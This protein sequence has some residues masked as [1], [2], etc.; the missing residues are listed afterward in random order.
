MIGDRSE[1]IAHFDQ[2]LV[3]YQEAHG[4][5]RRLFDYRL[6]PVRRRCEGR[7]RG[8]YSLLDLHPKGDM[9]CWMSSTLGA[10]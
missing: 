2:S 8:D 9:P 3:G 10:F 6:G 4:D 1:L 5:A 7:E